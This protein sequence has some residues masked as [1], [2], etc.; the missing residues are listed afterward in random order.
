MFVP[1]LKKYLPGLAE[2][3]VRRGGTD[4][5]TDNL[6]MRDPVDIVHHNQSFKGPLLLPYIEVMI[7]AS[8]FSLRCSSERGKR[9]SKLVQNTHFHL[10]QSSD[11]VISE[12]IIV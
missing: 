4:W 1:H 5:R 9:K 3:F 7:K 11:P 10:P 2:I 12:F 8:Q 6:K